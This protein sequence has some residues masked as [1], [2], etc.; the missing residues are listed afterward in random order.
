MDS[1]PTLSE[2]LLL[3]KI[4]RFFKYTI[5]IEYTILF[6]HTQLEPLYSTKSFK[7]PPLRHYQM[8]SLFVFLDNNR[9]QF[10]IL[11]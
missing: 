4:L 11:F 5:Y 7:I 6:L 1:L 3:P 2:H 9:Q 10:Y 8:L